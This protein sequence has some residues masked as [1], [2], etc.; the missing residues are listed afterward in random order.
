MRRAVLLLATMAIAILAASG[1]AQAIINGEPDGDMHPYVGWAST[2][3]SACSG[4]LISPTVFLTAG[5]CTEDWGTSTVYVT[6]EPEADFVPV[7]LDPD[8]VFDPGDAYTGT[9]YTHPDYDGFF[10][11]VGVVVLDEPVSMATYGAL[12]DAGLVDTLKKR[13][14][15]SAVGYGVRNF[16]VGGGP[17]SI[18]EFA[19]R[20]KANVEYLGTTGVDTGLGEDRFIKTS[21]ASA[22]KG[23]EGT[24]FG[25]SGGPYFLP[26][27]RTIVAIT[28]FGLNGVCAG[29]GYGQRIDLPVVLGWVRS[30]L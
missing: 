7:E 26:N 6:F 11:D 27:E 10:P 2:E 29:V 30:F 5:H 20:Y 18:G 22:G 1:V 24:C 3:E 23:G 13:T 12:P 17:P 16:E 9:A 25:D 8:G 21:E 15:L 14:L 4:T 19:I 28:S